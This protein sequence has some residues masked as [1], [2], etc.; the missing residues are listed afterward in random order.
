MVMVWL[1]KSRQTLPIMQLE[2]V[3]LVVVMVLWL[4]WWHLV[5]VALKRLLNLQLNLLLL[6]LLLHLLLLLLLL[7]LQ[8]WLLQLLLLLMMWLLLSLGLQLAVV[9]L[10][11]QQLLQLLLPQVPQRAW[12]RTLLRLLRMMVLMLLILQC[13]LHNDGGRLNHLLDNGRLLLLLQRRIRLLLHIDGLTASTR[14]RRLRFWGLPCLCTISV[15]SNVPDHTLFLQHWCNDSNLT[16]HQ[17][18]CTW[19]GTLPQPVTPQCHHPMTHHPIDKGE[20]H[21]NHTIRA[22]SFTALSGHCAGVRGFP[23][24]QLHPAS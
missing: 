10:R 24:S 3:M 7:L 15:L 19:D 12:L 20:L 17:W 8:K 2:M 4:V 9:M 18:P 16:T 21:F 11:L 13:S 5:V 14:M 23:T 22:G 6:L 1:V